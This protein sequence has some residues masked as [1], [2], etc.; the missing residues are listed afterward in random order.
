VPDEN[1]DSAT[2]TGKTVVVTGATAGIGLQTAR[3]LAALGA[4]IIL[5]GRDPARCDRALAS[6]HPQA[7]SPA[8]IAHVADLSM[9]EQVRALGNR[10]LDQEPRVDV[11]VNNIGAMFASRLVTGEGL[12]QTLALNHLGPFLL[13]SLLL[14]RLRRSAPA[15]VVNVSSEAH[16]MGKINFDDLQL[17]RN[18]SAFRAYGQSKLANLLFTREL[19]RRLEGSGVVAH[20]L[21]PG[22]VAS[23][24]ANGPGLTHWTMR[25][26]A[27]LFAISTEQGAETSVHVATSPEPQA[28]NGLYYVKCRPSTP[29]SAAIDDQAARLLW[30]A[31]A[32]ITRSGL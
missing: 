30:D 4:R 5:V 3:K 9:L 18:Y 2:M 15:R 10:I 28:L 32:S 11:L 31:T 20:A 8:H 17:T 7:G 27:S 6:L 14:E 19:A 16:R 25:R 21:H 26:L 13:T 22:F 29:S 23:D 24:F 1:H 12:E